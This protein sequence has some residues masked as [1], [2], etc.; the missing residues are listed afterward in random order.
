VSEIVAELHANGRWEPIEI[1]LALKMPSSRRMR[2]PECGGRVRSHKAGTTG[3]KAH[4]EHYKRHEGC[5]RGDCFDGASR[6]HPATL[7]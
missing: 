4:M 6:P 7:A 5:S 3:Q 1:E 2:C